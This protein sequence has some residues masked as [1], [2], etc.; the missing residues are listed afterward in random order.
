MD[1]LL[2]APPI[3]RLIAAARTAPASLPSLLEELHRVE[4]ALVSLVTLH[5]DAFTALLNGSDPLPA[6]PET[7]PVDSYGAA[8]DT[9]SDTVSDAM[10]DAACPVCLEACGSSSEFVAL[11]CGHGVHLACWL[12][13]VMPPR[14]RR[15]RAGASH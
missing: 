10:S 11:A 13:C 8:L 6:P 9:V 7:K 2:A 15:H 1:K 14:R 5:R 12:P 3:V 4:P